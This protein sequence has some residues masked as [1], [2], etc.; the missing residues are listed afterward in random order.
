MRTLMPLGSQQGMAMRFLYVWPNWKIISP[1]L[2]IFVSELHVPRMWLSLLLPVSYWFIDWYWRTRGISSP[3]SPQKQTL[4]GIWKSFRI[5]K[6]L[7]FSQ[8]A[9]HFS[10]LQ[11][12]HDLNT[13]INEMTRGGKQWLAMLYCGVYWVFTAIGHNMRLQSRSSV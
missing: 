2:F 1:H 10:A 11:L 3:R 8:I 9:W 4:M 5:H 6:H 13:F 12:T 7:M